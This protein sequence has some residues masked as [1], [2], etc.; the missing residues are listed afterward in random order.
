VIAVFEPK[1]QIAK[2]RNTG[3]G[4]AKGEWL[5]FVDADTYPPPE[6]IAELQEVIRGGMHVGCGTTIEVVGGT[7]INKL[8]MER[9]NPLYRLLSLCGGAFLLCHREAFGAIA[10]FSTKLYALEEIDSVI[11]LK[12]NARRKGKGFAILYRH[13]AITSGRKGDYGFFSL[14]TLMASDFFAVLLFCLQ[15]VLPEVVIEKI[16]PRL[17]GYWYNHRK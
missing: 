11:R 15:K 10:G 5:L 13:P 4:A 1:N 8:R 2:A 3:A 7:L 12:R 17:L 9:L 14:V 6:L 16:G